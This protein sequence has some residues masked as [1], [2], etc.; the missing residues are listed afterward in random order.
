MSDVIKAPND[1]PQA[2][3]IRKETNWQTH[4]R[5]RHEKAIYVPKSTVAGPSGSKN[6]QGQEIENPIPFGKGPD[7]VH[8]ITPVNASDIPQR[9]KQPVA[10][11]NAF[12]ALNLHEDEIIPHIPLR[13]A[14]ASIPIPI[15]S[16]PVSP[17]PAEKAPTQSPMHPETQ[18]FQGPAIQ[19]S[20]EYTAPSLE[21]V[22]VQDQTHSDDNI[23]TK[24]LY[25][26]D[27]Q[28]SNP[29]LHDGIFIIPPR[30]LMIT[31]G[32]ELSEGEEEPVVEVSNYGSDSEVRGRRYR[33]YA[34]QLMV[35][36]S[37]SQGHQPS[38]KHCVK[39]VASHHMECPGCGQ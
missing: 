7:A 32:E 21:I 19:S 23:P 33:T 26:P 28:A 34:P 29:N 25:A 37:R 39:H 17:V 6:S 12:E 35:T 16:Q 36:R 15:Q 22:T 4:R 5:Y 30:P 27:L 3:K 31:N 2:P 24:N 11:Y 1:K 20:D 13:K 14:S 9:E 18:V 38:S 8:N 10:T